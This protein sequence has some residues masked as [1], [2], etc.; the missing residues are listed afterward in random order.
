MHHEKLQTLHLALDGYKPEVCQDG[1]RE[2]LGFT[3][4]RAILMRGL[5]I[6]G[7]VGAGKSVLMDLFFDGAPVEHKLRVHFHEFLQDVHNRF[8][9]LR[10]SKNKHLGDPIPI[11]AEKIAKENIFKP[12]P[13]IND[14]PK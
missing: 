14:I 6:Y 2:R 12:Y 5:Y 3:N 8:N 13:N 9:L 1:W 4:R 7:G 10:K 11:V